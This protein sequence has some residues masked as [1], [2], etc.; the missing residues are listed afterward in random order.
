MKKL[1]LLFFFIVGMA[2]TSYAQNYNSALG[3]RLGYPLSIT[4]KKFMN[5]NNAFEFHGGARFYS[6]Y[7]SYNLNVGYQIHNDIPD[8]PALKWYYGVGAGVGFY[9][10]DTGFN[11]DDDGLSI[12]LNGYLGLE[13][14]L[15]DTPLSFSVDWVPTY[16]IGGYG[17]GFGADGGALAVRY[18]LNR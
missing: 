6:F 12:L 1:L 7:S 8:L 15:P 4:Y 13:Y 11:V 17:D 16:Y 5:A 18:I 2:F 14:T 10:F 3:L 9:S